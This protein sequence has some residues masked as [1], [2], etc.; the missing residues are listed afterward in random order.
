[1][2][3]QGRSRDVAAPAASSTGGGEPATLVDAEMLGECLAGHLGDRHA[4]A[5]RLVTEPRVK[6]VG[7]LD[8]G[9][10]HGDASVPDVCYRC[11]LVR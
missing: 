3:D 2:S 5:L 7:K 1:V 9:A 11:A 8:R 4:A 10:A 6:V